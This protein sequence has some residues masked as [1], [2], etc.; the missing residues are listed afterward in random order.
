MSLNFIFP[1]CEYATTLIN[2]IYGRMSRLS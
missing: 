1:S 2:T